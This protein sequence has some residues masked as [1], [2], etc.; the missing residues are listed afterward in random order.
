MGLESIGARSSVV[1]GQVY[2]KL[3]VFLEVL[4]LALRWRDIMEA[5]DPEQI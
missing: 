1:R 3:Q 2:I 5:T 4:S